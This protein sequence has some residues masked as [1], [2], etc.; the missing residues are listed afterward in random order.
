MVGRVG[1]SVTPQTDS[2]QPRP[3]FDAAVGP[4]LEGKQHFALQQPVFQTHWLQMATYPTLAYFVVTVSPCPAPPSLT[5]QVVPNPSAIF[6]SDRDLAPNVSS[7][8]AGALRGGAGRGR[9]AGWGAS[10]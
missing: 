6:L 9:Q 1:E 10:W 5:L 2:P 3:T 7:A 4:R 8:V